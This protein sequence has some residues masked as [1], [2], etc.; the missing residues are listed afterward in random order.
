MMR[1]THSLQLRFSIDVGG[2]L[3]FGEGKNRECGLLKLKKERP[4]S[5]IKTIW[6]I[7]CDDDGLAR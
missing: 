7:F 3:M 1:W 4:L 2:S 6:G 5:A